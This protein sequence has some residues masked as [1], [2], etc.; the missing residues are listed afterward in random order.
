MFERLKPP[1]R[2]IWCATQGETAS[3]Q[4]RQI[5]AR[6]VAIARIFHELPHPAALRQQ[7]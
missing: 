4:P 6:F 7:R 3:S 5:L 2:A 1:N